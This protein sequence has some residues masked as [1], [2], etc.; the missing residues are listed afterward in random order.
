[1]LDRFEISEAHK[2]L[3][4]ALVEV[5]KA[6]KRFAYV[7]RGN[8]AQPYYFRKLRYVENALISILNWCIAA[9]GSKD[10]TK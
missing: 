2:N 10:V 8:G 3:L 6:R 9:I 7:N 4:D 5:Q 1:M